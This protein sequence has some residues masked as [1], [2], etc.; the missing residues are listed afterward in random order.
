MP[1]KKAR[2]PSEKLNLKMNHEIANY[3]K[4]YLS[5]NGNL[6]T[7]GIDLDI[8]LY[9]K[10]LF[11]RDGSSDFSYVMN[12]VAFQPIRD[13]LSYIGG[14]ALESE[15]AAFSHPTMNCRRI[16]TLYGTLYGEDA[17]NKRYFAETSKEQHA[18]D[19][20]DS[21]E[22]YRKKFIAE[23]D[24]FVKQSQ[25]LAR[26]EVEHEELTRSEVEHE[27]LTLSEMEYED[28]M[29][30]IKETLKESPA[31]ETQPVYGL[32]LFFRRPTSHVGVPHKSL[33]APNFEGQSLFV[34]KLIRS[35]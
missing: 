35:V 29:L 28:L 20:E 26:S 9:I 34:R 22:I 30:S 5:T 1:K 19:V 25:D 4:D 3:L 8:L 16:K 10:D 7:K 13:I 11:I 32:P 15:L 17:E 18:I 31:Q 6:R 23:I 21:N 12:E 14:L 2:S 24:S 27:E 33:R